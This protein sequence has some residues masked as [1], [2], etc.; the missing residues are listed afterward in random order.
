MPARTTVCGLF[1]AESLMVSVPVRGPEAD[2]AKTTF[3]VHEE[4]DDSVVPQLLDGTEKSPDVLIAPIV[5]A[6][7]LVFVIV[8]V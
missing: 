5:S 8:T 6:C 7:G 3:A 2:G 4:E 1:V